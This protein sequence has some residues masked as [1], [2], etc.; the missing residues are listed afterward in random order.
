MDNLI[1]DNETFTDLNYTDKAVKGREFQSCVFK[2]CELSNSDFSQNKFL[3]CVFDG[4]NLSM[5]KLGKSTLND[6]VFKN[7]KIL[8]VNFHECHDFLFTV[9]FD[10]CIL[11]Y[12]SFMGKK[13][14]KTKFGRSSLKEV[15]F[16]QANL[17]GSGF[18]ECDLS[19]T[20]F[21]QT[22][23]SSVNFVTAYNYTIDPELNSLKKAAFSADG[24]QGL[25]SKYQIR[26]V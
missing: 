22:D 26:V 9:S 14:I 13:M 11:D 16:I 1:Y 3:D 2:K 5:M 6:V 10:S 21:S 8:G 23:L 24:L 4:C 19:G 12:S 18:D 25:L 17:S 20:I 15:N 7:C